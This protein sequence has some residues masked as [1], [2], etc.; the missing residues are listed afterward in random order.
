MSNSWIQSFR[1]RP[2][3]G[4]TVDEF[5]QERIH[6]SVR[7]QS[8]SFVE[9]RLS[10]MQRLANMENLKEGDQLMLDYLRRKYPEEAIGMDLSLPR[11]TA[12]SPK[13]LTSGGY[14]R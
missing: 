6:L 7:E 11:P 8:K 9:E 4:G 3:R 12:S 13:P 5:R 2:A 14:C 1:S 10:E